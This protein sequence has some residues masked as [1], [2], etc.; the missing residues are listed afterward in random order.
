MTDYWNA[1]LE[2]R[3]WP[4]LERWQAAQATAMLPALRRRSRLYARLHATVPGDLVLRSAADLAALPF[5]L[6]DDLR[7]AQDAATDERPFGDN[8][9][10]AQADIVQAISSSGTTGRPLYYALTARDVDTIGD[11]VANVW[12]TA[13]IRKDDVVAHL[14]GL[15][16]VAGGLPYA[17]GFR[18]IGATLCWLGGFPTE[19]IL[20]EM[21]HLR[22]TALLATTSFALHL[23]EQWEA[24]GR[25]TGVGSRLR[26]VIG[27]GEPGL[28]QPEVRRRIT[29][30]LALT[31]LRETMG[32]GDVIPSM[33]GEC[34]AEDGMHF[35]AR[36]H[37]MIELVDPATGQALPWREGATGEIVYTAL[38]RDATPVVRYRSRDHAA[39][40]AMG[41]ACGRTGP[42]IR[43]IGRTDDMLIY[44]G[45]NVFPTAIRDL[46]VAR[47]AGRVEPVLRLWKERREQVRFD[48]PIDV[49]VEASAGLD[50]DARTALA[51]EIEEAVRA[52]LQVRIAV[53][54]LER[55]G[56]PRGVYKNAIAAVRDP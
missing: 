49:D 27:G 31:H 30:A 8:Q 15:P 45:M 56:L 23:A 33:W 5:T 7:A 39:V 19:R 36:A 37:V 21:R 10:A 20:R 38:D 29:G 28:G 4:E 11:A 40:L 44:K 52:A 46:V 43:C 25:E 53:T 17:D 16:M 50:G 3:P 14:V 51:R 41:C 13:G 18:R 6:K 54:V 32:L 24:V 34:E 26:K 35:N 1:E 42:R 12:F 2:T 55:G 47:F 22:V 48:R 9:G